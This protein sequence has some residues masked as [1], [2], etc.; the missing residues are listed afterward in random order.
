[1]SKKK[2]KSPFT[3]I[4]YNSGEGMMTAVWGPPMWHILHTISFNYPTKPTEEQKKNYYNYYKNLKNILPCKFCRDNLTNNLKNHKLTKAVMKNRDT[5][6]RWV[7]QL[8]EI[9]NIMLGKKSGLSY[10]KVRDR[11]EKFR[12]RCLN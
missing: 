9:V 11:Y 4:D 10:E 7:Y 12:S 1:M 5:L 8:H 6:S 3:E 2:T